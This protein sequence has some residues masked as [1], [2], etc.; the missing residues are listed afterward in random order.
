MKLFA[1]GALVIALAGSASAE[2]V[3]PPTTID[4]EGVRVWIKSYLKVDGW[5]LIAADGGAVAFGSPEGVSQ[6][7]DKTLTAQIRHE[8][9]HPMRMGDFDSRSNLQTWNIDCE[10]KRM[11]IVDIAIFEDNN[12]AG[13]SQ[14]R[15]FRNAE[16]TPVEDKT[17]TRGRTFRRICEAPTTG[18]RLN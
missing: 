12:L 18:H 4:D 10:H 9:Y 8:F 2:P 6:G 1:A 14:A 13:R 15:S 3:P 7:A 16:W 17:S 5:T 11:R